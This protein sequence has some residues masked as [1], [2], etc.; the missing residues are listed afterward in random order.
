MALWLQ[1]RGVSA[2]GGDFNDG[3]PPLALDSRPTPIDEALRLSFAW[4]CEQP[5][6]AI[7]FHE[8]GPK[9]SSLLRQSLRSC[10]TS[11]F[12]PYLL[13]SEVFHGER[14]SPTYE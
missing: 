14:T 11:R 6:R 12:S 7:D 1:E 4:Y 5:R 8:P 9:P 2:I 13:G 10:Q 3:S